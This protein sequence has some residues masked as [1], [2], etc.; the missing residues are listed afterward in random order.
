MN[1]LLYALLALF[2]FAALFGLYDYYKQRSGRADGETA[3]P[4]TPQPPRAACGLTDVCPGQAEKVMA[5]KR[6]GAEVLV[7]GTCSE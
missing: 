5:L 3:E 6:G 7:V 1:V 2:G 4:E